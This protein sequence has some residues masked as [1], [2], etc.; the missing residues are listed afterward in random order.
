MSKDQNTKEE[1]NSKITGNIRK[2][3]YMYYIYILRQQK[4]C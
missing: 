1:S 3:M 4:L 2:Y